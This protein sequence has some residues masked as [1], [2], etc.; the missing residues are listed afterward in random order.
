MKTLVTGLW[1][2]TQAVSVAAQERTFRGRVFCQH[3]DV[4]IAAR[5]H[6]LF[7]SADEGLT[8]REIMRLPLTGAMPAKSLTPLLQ[9]LFRAHVYHIVPTAD[10]TVVVFGFRCIYVCDLGCRAVVRVVA[11]HGSRPLAVCRVPD[12]RLYY[13]EYRGNEERRPMRVYGSEDGG[14]TW[15]EAYRFY[16]VRHVHGVYYDRY[17]DAVWVTT[18]DAD[19]EAGIW[20]SYDNLRTLR[21]I[22]GGSQQA[23]VIRLVFTEDHVYFGSD[24]PGEQNHIYRLLPESGRVERLAEVGG[25]V[26]H[27]CR[28]AGGL[29][30]STACE[31][32]RVNRLRAA[33]VWYSVDGVAWRR[34]AEYTK[35]RWPMRLFQYG[36]VFFAE[37]DDDAL[38]AWLSPFATRGHQVSRYVPSP[39][40]GPFGPDLVLRAGACGSR[41]VGG[42]T[43]EERQ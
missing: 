10:G 28:T 33:Q 21:R 13:G 2:G 41:S 3:G 36:Q 42:H 11:L 27:G 43:S 8:W 26:W 12:G 18:G 35:D 31:P 37:G 20:V 34:V 16:G 15:G 7:A 17:R 5:R 22:V 4:L 40:G 32:S 25:P 30:F 39:P 1:P 38:G 29:L 9:R 24:A 23:R 6:R 14:R 19:D